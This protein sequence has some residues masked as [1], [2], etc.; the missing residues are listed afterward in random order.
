MTIEV[1]SNYTWVDITNYFKFEGVD[2]GRHDV[3][4][5]SAGRD[6]SG[7]MHRS[8]VAVKQRLD[9]QTVP[10]TNAQTALLYSYILPEN[11]RFRI[12][13]YPSTNSAQIFTVYSNEV[14]IHYLINREAG[15]LYTMSFPLVEV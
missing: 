5:P 11:V 13:P 10:L 1:E 8:R 4:A 15:D 12:T 2:F 3:E 6:M 9:L 14:S 7:K